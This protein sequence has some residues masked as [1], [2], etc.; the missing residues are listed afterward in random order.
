MPV[1]RFEM[2]DGRVARFEVADGTTPEQ[3]QALIESQIAQMTQPEQPQAQPQQP[4]PSFY[5]KMRGAAEVAGTMASGII[6]EP[7]AGIAGVAQTLNPFADEGAGG[8]AVQGTREAMTYQPQTPTGQQYLQNVGETIAPVANA[9]SGAENWLGDTTYN[10]TGSPLLAAAAKTAPT[11]AM[12]LLGL[13]AGKGV[14]KAA[15]IAEAPIDDAAKS[16]LDAAKQFDVRVMTSDILPPKTYAGKM[17]QNLSEKMGFMGTGSARAEQQSDRIAAVQGF[18]EAMDI[19]LDSPFAESVVKSINRKMASDIKEA[20]NMRSA[21]IT[22]LDTHG[23]VDISR[24]RNAIQAQIAKQQLLKERANVG[25]I[26]KLEDTLSALD[27]GDFSQVARIRTEVID[28]IKSL[29]ASGAMGSPDARNAASFQSVKSAIDED[30]KAFAINKD[31]QAASQWI[32]SNR[33]F[34]DAYTKAK[35]TELKQIIMR[36]DTTPE[37]LIPVLKRGRPSELNRIYNSLDSDG[38]EAARR[39]IIQ[40]ALKDSKY[41]ETDANPNPDAFATVMNRPNRQQAVNAFFKGD[42]RKEIDGLVRL[43]DSTRRAQQ[44]S[45][46]VKTGEQAAVLGTMGALGYTTATGAANPSVL[47]ALGTGSALIKAYESRPFRHFLLKLGNT[48]PGGPAERQLLLTGAATFG[49][50]SQAAKE[51]QE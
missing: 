12:E 22:A 34:A 35:D 18:A 7:V 45:A 11:A 17:A 23:P 2:P 40:D 4:E 14:S 16:V 51:Q 21:A 31:R 50:G 1:A 8:R 33:K 15:R 28:D 36:G 44:A 39:A 32:Q 25:H 41:F 3:A 48:R 9:I 29:R 43:L 26:Q 37:T 42:A 19:D 24:T 13:A 20:G 5:D 47:A 30:M 49:A 6:A 27:N 10:A 46:L 38:R